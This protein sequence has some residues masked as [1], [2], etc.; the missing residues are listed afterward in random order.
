MLSVL[1]QYYRASAKRYFRTDALAK[2][3]IA[4]LFLL[5]G[6]LL[7]V[8]FYFGAYRSFLYLLNDPFFGQALSLYIIELFLLISSLLV[9]A[10]ALITGV[11]ALFRPDDGPVLLSSPSYDWKPRIVLLRMFVTSLW[12]LLIIIIPALIAIGRAFHLSP[13]YL[14]PG[15]LA[16]ILLVCISVLAA[17]L[18][19]FLM[20]RLLVGF[21]LFSKRSVLLTSMVWFLFLVVSVW[22]RFRAVDLIDFFRAQLLSIDVAPIAPIVEQ[23][24][25]F[26]SHLASMSI[27]YGTTQV[28]GSAMLPLLYSLLLLVVLIFAFLFMSRTYL[29]LWQRAQEGTRHTSARFFTRVGMLMSEARN[30]AGALFAKEVLAFLRNDRGMLWLIFILVIWG[31][32]VGASQLLTRGLGVEH[33][34]G[35][36]VEGVAGTFLFVAVVYFIALFVLRFAF[37]SFSEEQKRNWVVASAPID[38]GRVFAAK[39]SFF[40]V[41]FSLFASAFYLLSAY[42]SGAVMYATLSGLVTVLVAVTTITTFGLALGALFPNTETDDPELLSTTMPGIALILGALLY[43]ALGAYLAQVGTFAMIVFIL[44]SIFVSR[45]FARKAGRALRSATVG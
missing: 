7:A 39:L 18:L 4:A 17:M 38:A 42:L 16:S 45:Y 14:L 12:P 31:I 22:D 23:F 2:R 20:C 10:S 1:F 28:L 35:A 33:V 44:V 27:Y 9:F 29:Y 43:G 26:P 40:T 25:V 41:V 19:I 3:I 24:H 11:L 15:M 30:P 36:A 21:R 8:L 13:I 32:Q 37:P 6:V 5:L 34:P